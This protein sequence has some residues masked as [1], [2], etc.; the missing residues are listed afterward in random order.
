MN[1]QPVPPAGFMVN[2]FVTQAQ[3]DEVR[4]EIDANKALMNSL[5][6]EI[7]KAQAALQK[8]INQRT[9]MQ[10]LLES[11]SAPSE[12]EACT[13]RQVIASK[14]AQLDQIQLEIAQAASTQETAATDRTRLVL[15]ELLR[16]RDAT[17]ETLEAH[18]ALLSPI[19]RI[20]PEILGEIF[21]HTL[22][23]ERVAAKDCPLLL[24]QVSSSWRAVALSTPALWAS[25]SVEITAEH[26]CPRIELVETWL[27]RSGSCPL[28]FSIKDSVQRDYCKEGTPMTAQILALYAPHY[29]RWQN[30]RLAQRDWRMDT[31]FSKLPTHTGPPMALESLDL[32]R[33]FWASDEQ[34]KLS[35]LLSAPHLRSCTWISNEDIDTIS[36]ALPQLRRLFLER[37]LKREQFFRTLKDGANI[38]ACRFFV[39]AAGTPAEVS[40]AL[41]ILNHNLSSLDL[42]A[43]LFGRLFSQL[44]LPRLVTLA[45]RRFDNVP[46]STP[47]WPHKELMALLARSRCALEDITLQDMDITPVEL[48][49][50]LRFVSSSLTKLQLTNDHR[51]RHTVVDDDVLR[52][53]TGDAVC[54]RLKTLR[55]W[56]CQ[57]STDGVMAD[58]VE[59]RW[60]PPRA[61]NMV[62][63]L[64]KEADHP[65]DRMRLDALN[66]ERI[67][68]TLLL[69]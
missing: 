48:C 43:D 16:Q 32:A 15:A 7:A 35:V 39:L 56:D 47:V 10:L 62:F 17:H 9:E 59:S 11:N 6:A 26:C 50:L 24:L 44:E 25:V 31:G 1:Q 49:G 30:V 64:L 67:G 28:S 38:A 27:G 63:C 33:D 69:R 2:V 21:L 36:V 37:P 29:H 60:L 55:I 65:I 61:L 57:T 5:D 54:P 53:L 19:R 68:I 40:K 22:R 42:T 34:K 58:M 12:S 46:H 14:E 8:L 4:D 20:P 52:L 13:I 41:P 18:R 66:K 3:A 51:M 45:V 23:G